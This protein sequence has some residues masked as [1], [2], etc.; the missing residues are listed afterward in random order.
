MF[1][2][3][4][5]LV[6]LLAAAPAAAQPP[7]W[8]V[9]D[10]D[11]EIVLFGS[12]HLLP[13]GLDWTPATLDAAVKKADDLWFELPVDM[14]SAQASALTAARRGV[15][16]KGESLSAK[17]SPE[18]RGRL[19]RLST[20][21]GAPHEAVERMRPWF[22]EMTLSL[23]MLARE[24]ASGSAGV[25]QTISQSAP[26]GAERRAFETLEEQ[27][28]FFADAPEAEQLASLEEALRQL[29]EEPGGYQELVD[30]WMDGD[31]AALDEM[32][33]APLRQASPLLYERL[34]VE[35]NRRWAKALEERLAGS[36]ETVVVVGAGHL[37]G[38]DGVPAL[39]RARGIAVEGP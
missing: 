20:R 19:A 27:I 30:A 15:L 23:L 18:G 3:L 36:G 29:E 24:G 12:V 10:A 37:I 21:L 38:A 1:A 31:L 28:G 4:T 14:A 6:A 25:E 17:L 26:A 7:V 16:P 35:R 39:L 8:V 13:E 9:R 33:I 32:A 2:R 22:A 5:F 11:S 34:I